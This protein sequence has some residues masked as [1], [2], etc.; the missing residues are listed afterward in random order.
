[1]GVWGGEAKAVTILYSTWADW[2]GANSGC[3]QHK[4]GPFCGKGAYHWW[5]S[6]AFQNGN[7]DAYRMMVNNDP[8]KPNNALIDYHADLLFQA[9]VDF[10]S[11]DLTNGEQD[12]IVNGAHALCRRYAQRDRA[13]TPKVVFFIQAET[14]ADYFLRNFYG[15][16]YPQDIFYFHEGKPL[17]LVGQAGSPIP[18]TGALAK[19]TARHTW[20]LTNSGDY[21]CFKQNTNFA[22]LQCFVKDGRCEQMCVATATQAQYMKNAQDPG[23]EGGKLCRNNGQTFQQQWNAVFKANPE[24]VFV[25]GWNEWGSQ[26]GGDENTPIF[27]DQWL[28]DCSSDIE[29]MQDGHGTSYYDAL[30]RNVA[31][32]KST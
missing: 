25:T 31:Q 30:K 13:N 28:E 10:V 32:Y 20:G 12:K 2:F 7:R 5:G 9:G 21:W 19:F 17:I 4:Q 14:S 16:Q 15:G 8:S 27:V 18:T 29:P 3:V 23:A 24:F 26:N 11:L 22:P 1:M 6:P